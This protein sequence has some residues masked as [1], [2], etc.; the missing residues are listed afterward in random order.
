MAEPFAIYNR[1]GGKYVVKRFEGT[2]NLWSVLGENYTR[3][4]AQRLADLLAAER[5]KRDTTKHA[6]TTIH[7][8]SPETI[9]AI[10]LIDES[11]TPEGSES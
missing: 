9:T 5:S 11:G 6:R 2:E 4:D 10:R 1:P 8:I 3:E 7:E